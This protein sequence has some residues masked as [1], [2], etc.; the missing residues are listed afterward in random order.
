MI[1]TVVSLQECADKL[2]PFCV[3]FVCA[4]CS[5]FPVGDM[6]FSPSPKMSRLG[7]VRFTGN[8]ILFIGVSGCLY[9]SAF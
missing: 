9:A 5:W 8:C 1:S 4:P 7:W 2:L 3:D 6:V